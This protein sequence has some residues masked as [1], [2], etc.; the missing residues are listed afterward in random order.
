MWSF[1]RN[2]S[3]TKFFEAAKGG[4]FNG[5]APFTFG[6][7]FALV[8]EPL[9]PAFI[10]GDGDAGSNGFDVLVGSASRPFVSDGTLLLAGGSDLNDGS[11]VPDSDPTGGTFEADDADFCNRI[12]AYM[13]PNTNPG[14]AG[15][16]TAAY[17]WPGI[18]AMQLVYVA[19]SIGGATSFAFCNGKVVGL[20]S[21]ATVPNAS[22]VR[23]GESV[24][25]GA[26]SGT[27]LIGG[28]F[29]HSSDLTYLQLQQHFQACKQAQDVANFG[30]YE[31]NPQL[32]YIWSVKRS[33]LWDGRTTW[34]SDGA[35]SSIDMV[36]QG[37]TPLDIAGA[38]AD[39]LALN[40][41]WM[42]V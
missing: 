3:T 40:L 34:A 10:F 9:G 33:R 28:C 13:D 36:K 22:G 23:I 7:V 15:G 6:A 2:M 4:V 29:Y 12:K 17:A 14:G 37:A 11:A 20:A 24:A 30:S 21:S 38:D 26:P 1:L 5:Q 8:D 32:D 42:T 27:A 35:Q 16:T 41:D 25:G 31:S 18:R 39:L 19:M